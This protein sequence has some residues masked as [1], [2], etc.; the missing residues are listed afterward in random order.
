MFTVG[1]SFT[2]MCNLRCK[3]CYNNSG[4][5]ESKELTFQQS[6][7]VVDKL[8]DFGVKAINFGGGECPLRNDFIKLCEY[9][10]E[11][12]DI[13]ISLTTNGTTYNIIKDK[14]NLFHDIGVSIDFGDAKRHDWNRGVLGTFEKATKTIK[15]LVE[16]NV[17]TEIV[18]CLSRFNANK[19]ELEKIYDLAKKLKVNYWRLNRYRPTGRKEI[20]EKLI[21]RKK[22]AFEAFG[23]LSKVKKNFR[24][25]DPLFR[26]FIGS[27]G[28][29]E[30]CA[31]GANSFRIRPDGS[32]SP[33]VYIKKSGGNILEKSIDDILNSPVFLSIKN[34]EPIGKCK[35][36][37]AYSTCKGGCAGSS[38][39]EYGHFN[40]PDPQCFL[41][42]EEAKKS[43]IKHSKIWNIHEVYLCTIYVPINDGLNV[44]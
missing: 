22:D 4:L 37:K 43:L 17:D 5:R 2:N 28:L 40:G 26:S 36:C 41:D 24:E 12:S 27:D 44:K 25:S 38:F 10:K 14:L 16:N 35:V 1:W 9:I 6:I 39:L 29:I 7:K 23:F 20:I 30:G 21:L 15:T 34:R 32:V 8:N 33:C 19:K 31:C 11:N 18:T 3:H 13:I 42:G